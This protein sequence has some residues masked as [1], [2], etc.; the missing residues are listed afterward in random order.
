MTERHPRSRTHLA[1]SLSP[2]HRPGKSFILDKLAC[3]LAIDSRLP[4]FLS[5]PSGQPAS[6]PFLRFRTCCHDTDSGLTSSFMPLWNISDR[7]GRGFPFQIRHRIMTTTS[8]LLCDNFFDVRKSRPLDK[9]PIQNLA[10]K[11]FQDYSVSF[12]RT[13][14]IGMLETKR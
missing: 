10:T 6:H 14:A 3:Q 13:L 2:N 4:I 11:N 7:K 9:H 8:E 1:S 5:Q 12:R